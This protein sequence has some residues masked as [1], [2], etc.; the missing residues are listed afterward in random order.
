MPRFPIISSIFLLISALSAAVIVPNTVPHLMPRQADIEAELSSRLFADITIGGNTRLRFAPRPQL[1]IENVQIVQLRPDDNML[2]MQVP[3]MIVNLSVL[4]LLQQKTIPTAVTLIGA[5]VN[6]KLAGNPAAFLAGLR[7]RARLMTDF[8]D[9]RFRVSGLNSLR[10]E[11]ATTIDDLSLRV[12]QGLAGGPLQLKARKRMDDGRYAT[13]SLLLRNSARQIKLALALAMGRDEQFQ[14]DGFISPR[15]GDWQLDGEIEL[16]SATLLADNFE[17]G[18]PVSVSNE[19]RN[20]RLAGLVR[21]NK[22]GILAETVEVELLNT[23]FR[24]RLMLDWP[25]NGEAKPVLSGRLSTGAVNL[26]ALSPAA[27]QPEDTELISAAASN[28]LSNLWQSFAPPL[29][30]DLRIEAT[31]FE[32]GGESGS[33]LALAFDWRDK[34]VGIERL[35]LNLPFSSTLLLSG[36]LDLTNSQIGFAGNFSARSSDA[37][38]AALWAGGSFGLDFSTAAERIDE[39]K[40]QR[41]SLVGD[42]LL[43]ESGL[44]INGLS[45]RVGDD[46]MTADMRI[47]DM[48]GPQFDTTLRIDRLDL[49]DWGIAEDSAPS[50]DGS[51]AAVWSQI[52][53]LLADNLADDDGQRVIALDVEIA[54]TFAGAQPLGPVALQ[55]RVNNQRLELD[56]L[57]LDN[58]GG[59]SVQASGQLMFDATPYYGAVQIDMAEQ[60]AGWI[61]DW[62]LSGFGPFGL[63]D[64]MPLSLQTEINLSAP[65][66]A[67]WPIVNLSGQGRLG[68]MSLVFRA[69][70]PSRTLNLELAG[71]D[72]SLNLGGTA[73]ALAASFALPPIYRNAEIGRLRLGVEAQTNELSALDGE[74]RM[75]DDSVSVSGTLRPTASGARMEGGVD[76]SFAHALP[77]MGVTDRAEQIA[78][79]GKTQVT[80]THKSVGFSALDISLGEGR[81][82]GEGVLALDERLP[83]LNM[84]LE[85]SDMDLAWLLPTHKGGWNDGPMEWSLMGLGN[86]DIGFQIDRLSLGEMRLEQLVGRAKLT[87]GVLE[88]PSLSLSLMQGTGQFNLQAEGGT[89][90]PRF[91]LDGEFTGLNPSAF[92]L[93]V[94]GNRLVDAPFD[95]ALRLSGRGTSAEN[96]MQ[97][98]NGEWR[99]D[100]NAGSLSVFDA[101][102]FGDEVMSAAFSGSAS[103]LAEKYQGKDELS[104]A[105]GVGLATLRDGLLDV[106]RMDFVFADGLNEARLQSIVDLLSLNLQ[107]SF[108]L[109]PVD[110]QRPVTWQLSG[111]L[112]KPNYRVDASAFDVSVETAPSAEQQP[113]R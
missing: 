68:D 67:D 74:L 12:E 17:Q 28:T 65:D 15:N 24:S 105:R 25:Q 100:I 61:K 104:F 62:M 54:E 113:A 35:N 88:A 13:A 39:N 102:G 33:N 21:G 52:T 78:L 97:S 81:L 92:F 10:P 90:P 36:E 59:A 101:I 37:I 7:A 40:L 55:A 42:V 66:A 71:S 23:Q 51:A 29:D 111:P 64:D 87:D 56:A 109:Y 32:L 41:A 2:A 80:A 73:N 34:I 50:R 26:D 38:A 110:R 18:M 83:R 46:T 95:G 96:M 43:N 49:V 107:G 82:S 5:D 75:A 58:M 47:A 99:Y 48:Q 94:Y 77:L 6:V 14:F 93:R 108:A 9:S 20:V 44:S 22:F 98:L 72:V 76:F 89:L 86:A 11:T 53:R 57:R 63:A 4:E 3:Q 60:Q 70:T 85:A 79:I 27:M 106:P 103:A 19:A 1:I 69:D 30:V 112:A 84:K 8:L 91:N 16:S 45:A 31:R